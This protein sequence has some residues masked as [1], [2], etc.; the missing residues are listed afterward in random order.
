MAAGDTAFALGSFLPALLLGVAVGNILRGLPLDADGEF[1]GSFVGLLNP[2]ALL[3]GL[4]S[5][6]M[7]VQH[8]SAWL[9]LKT[10]DDL[11]ERAAGRTAW[12]GFLLLWAATTLASTQAAP[13][14]W[15]AY[16]SP[17]A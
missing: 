1:A 8:G 2:F 9:V 17:L 5:V 10:E 12:A 15:R 16:G 4:T 13:H 14:L 11:R 6:A 7:F 3:V